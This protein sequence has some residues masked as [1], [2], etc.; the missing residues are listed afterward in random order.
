M[1]TLPLYKTDAADTLVWPVI[2]NP[3]SKS[4]SA[5]VVFT[6][7]KQYTPHVINAS[8]P[9]IKVE[10]IMRQS[11]VRM[12]L[13]V[14][15]DNEFIGVVTADDVDEQHIM[16]RTVELNVTREELQ[17]RDFTQLKTSL[18]SFDFN[19]L[20]RSSVGD[21]IETLKDYGQHHCLVLDRNNHEVRGVISVS[22]I[23]RG[24]KAPLNIQDKPTFSQLIQVLAA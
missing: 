22:D 21:V 1:H 7:F 10:N 13:V 19:E 15:A 11:H 17:V 16:Q 24:L 8:E 2:E 18:M 12:M 4:S 9:A 20:V 3:I 23:A 14:N 5:M 6:D